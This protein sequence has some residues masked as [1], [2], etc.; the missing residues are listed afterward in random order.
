MEKARKIRTNTRRGEVLLAAR[1]LFFSRGYRGTTIQEIAAHAGYS[2]RAVY[3]DFPSKDEIFI[4]ICSEGLELLLEKLEGIPCNTLS[5]EA[6]ISRMLQ[7]YVD[8]SRDHR[9]YFRMIFGE[10]TA[11]NMAN[12]SAGLR[13]RIADLERACLATL[14]DLAERAVAEKAIRPMDPR[15]A[16]GIFVGTA[17]GII[18]LSMGGSQ[19]VFSKE[20]LESLVTQAIMLIWKGMQSSGEGGA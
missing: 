7:V 5:I 20:T 6:C 17:T 4:R 13:D 11:E 16:A 2:K 1:E 8:F 14:E 15:E 10:A 9:E 18:L 3:L 12:C 19:T